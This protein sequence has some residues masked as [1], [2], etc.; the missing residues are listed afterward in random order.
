[1][2]LLPVP[3]IWRYITIVQTPTRN[4]SAFDYKILFEKAKI[5]DGYARFVLANNMTGKLIPPGVDTT[6]I[7]S[8]GLNT[9]IKLVYSKEGFDEKP[10]IIYG[11]GDGQVIL[12][13]LS[14][15]IGNWKQTNGGREFKEYVIQNV[16]HM[17]II[18]SKVYVNKVIKL[19]T[20]RDFSHSTSD[21]SALNHN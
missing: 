10:K 15:D 16:H 19:L 6:N 12:R 9:P 21:K 3:H 13:S 2:I 17:E 20:Q 8:T 14:D 18:K 7:Y 1:M 4:Y 11:D 5:E